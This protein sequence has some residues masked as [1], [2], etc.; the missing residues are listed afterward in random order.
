[1]RPL[2]QRQ[3]ARREDGRG[4]RTPGQPQLHPRPACQHH[5]EPRAG[6]VG[7]NRGGRHPPPQ[8]VARR[9]CRPVRLF[10]LRTLFRPAGRCHTRQG[11]LRRKALRRLPRHLAIPRRTCP[12]HRTMGIPGRPGGHGAADVEPQ[13]LYAGRVCTPQNRMAGT[14]HRSINRHGGMAALASGNPAPGRAFPIPPTATAIGS[15]KSRAAST[16]TRASLRSKTACTT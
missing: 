1:M 14:H 16:A 9:C 5:V 3:R 2:P 6:D 7:R 8:T 4:F 15:S 11:H 13:Q 10:L 12:A